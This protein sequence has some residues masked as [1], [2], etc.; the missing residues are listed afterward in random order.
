MYLAGTGH[1]VRAPEDLVDRPPDLVIAM[2]AIYLDEIRAQLHGL[3]LRAEVV[4]A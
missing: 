2:N 4:A 3:G 1:E